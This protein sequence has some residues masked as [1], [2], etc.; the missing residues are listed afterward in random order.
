MMKPIPS[1][2]AAVLFALA[3]MLGSQLFGQI[4]PEAQRIFDRYADAIGGRE[5]YERIVSARWRTTTDIPSLGMSMEA[6]MI[7][8]APDRIYME[9]FIPGM[10]SM[11][12]GFDGEKGW[13]VDLIQG[14]RELKGAELAQWRSDADF[15]EGVNFAEKYAS[16]SVVGVSEEGFV[17]VKAV[18]QDNSQEETLYFEKDSGLLRKSETIEFM[19]PEGEL[20]V[21]TRMTRYEAYGQLLLPIEFEAEM[22]GMEMNVHIVSFEPNVEVDPSIFEMPE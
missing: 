11:K 6:T 14:S 2:L 19:G 17:T 16:A 13:S 15:K 20:P 7:F 12:Q 18:N 3:S 1:R 5:A 22:M 8:L 10:G 9:V 4:D 21:T